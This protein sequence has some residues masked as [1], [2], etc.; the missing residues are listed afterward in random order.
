MAGLAEPPCATP[1]GVAATAHVYVDRLDDIVTVVGDDGHHLQ[2]ARRVR[3]GETVTAADGYGRWRVFTVADAAAGTVVL[4]AS[5]ALAH[6]PR[7]TPALTVACSLTKGEK[8][9]LA[10]QKL[11]ELGVDRI[12]LVAAARSVVQWD[13]TKVATAMERLQRVAREAGAQ[14]RRARIPVVDG[15][16]APIELLAHEGLVV[17]APDG[18][19]ADALPPPVGGEWVVAVGPEG[20]FDPAELA[21]FGAVARLAIGPFVLRAETAAIAV[22]AALSGRRTFPS[23][24]PPG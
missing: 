2:R 7:L 3:P 8:P 14:S 4:H 5:S 16:V 9:E 23:A 21:A 22:A 12:M 11:T 18:V 13:D 19:P 20:G 6:E 1:A 15:P 24:A 17:A 10:V